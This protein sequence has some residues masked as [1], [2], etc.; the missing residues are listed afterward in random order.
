MAHEIEITADGK[1][2]YIEYSETGLVTA[3]HQGGTAFSRGIGYEEAIREARLDYPVAKVPAYFSLVDGDGKKFVR[4]SDMCFGVMRTD[5]NTEL[6]RV[7]SDYECVQNV[8][9]FRPIEE[10]MNR[11]LLT[12]ETAGVLRGGADAWILGKFDP[13]KMGKNFQ[14][15]VGGEVLP[16]VLFQANHSGRSENVIAETPIRVVCANTLALAEHGYATRDTTQRIRHGKGAVERTREAAENLMADIVTR[17]EKLAVNFKLM[18]STKLSDAD[19]I[20]LVVDKAAT[21]PRKREEWNPEGRNAEALIERYETKRAELIRAARDP[22]GAFHDDSAWDAYNGAVQVIDHNTDLFPTKGG[23]LR[24]GAL[25]T[26]VLRKTK[27]S[28]LDAIISHCEGS[29]TPNIDR[30]L[31]ASDN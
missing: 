24:H 1:W 16:F 10:L 2:S 30:I 22:I 12:I 4:K 9:H 20:R 5:T 8:E 11:G 17:Y 28:I 14:E 21:D 23:A 25:M 26:G 6:G 13:D 18:K 31:A 15:V 7:G 19:V 3:W 29:E 27:D